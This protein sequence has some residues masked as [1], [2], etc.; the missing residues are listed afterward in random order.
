M[1][2]SRFAADGLSRPV[3]D[4]AELD[5]VGVTQLDQLFRSLLAAVADAAVYQDQLL[6]V[7][8]FR[9]V[10]GADGLVGKIDGSG[11]MLLAVFLSSPHI[12]NDIATSVIIS[13][14]LLWLWRDYF[15][16]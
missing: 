16:T 9:N 2:L 8:Q 3:I 4:A 11:D 5:D 12:Q 10:F 6:I 14:F 7:R 13:H 1:I 15:V